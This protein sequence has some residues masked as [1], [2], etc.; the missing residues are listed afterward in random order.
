MESS[1]MRFNIG[2]IRAASVMEQASD[3]TRI[4]LDRTKRPQRNA[5]VKEKLIPVSSTHHTAYPKFY[6]SGAAQ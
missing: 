3:E 5:N 2:Q 1:P 4:A 6:D